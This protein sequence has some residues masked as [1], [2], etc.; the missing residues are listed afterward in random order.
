M[1]QV[2]ARYEEITGWPAFPPKES[3]GIWFQINGRIKGEEGPVAVA[4]KFRALGLPMDYFTSVVAMESTDLQEGL[5]IIRDMSSQLGQ[6]GI[7]VGIHVAPFL[8]MDSEIGRE[9]IAGGYALMKKDG[10]PYEAILVRGSINPTAPAAPKK[11]EE[12]LEAVERDDAWRDRFY[13]ANRFASVAPD[14]TN[15]A[16]VK[17]WKDKV[18]QYMKAGCFGVGMS[19]FGED[20]PAD[21]HYYNKK[22]GREMHNLYTLLYHKA[23]YEAV[24]EIHGPPGIDQ[25]ALRDRGDAA[26]PDLLVGRSAMPMGGDGGDAARRALPRALRGAVLEQRYRAATCLPTIWRREFRGR[27]RSCTFAGCRCPCCNRTRGSTG[28][29]CGCLGILA[30]PR[31]RATGSTPRFGIG[32]CLT[33]IRTLTTLR[34]PVCR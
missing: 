7:K 23:T 15:P 5:G 28:R 33:F 14:F 27:L 32:C 12:T 21:A 2:L 24:V 11:I 6:V 17:W 16:A 22:T 10:S 26:L 29:R 25:R 13:A 34:R 30:M 8:K 4:K 19:D 18:G 3:F 1:K 31:W 9:A 20:N